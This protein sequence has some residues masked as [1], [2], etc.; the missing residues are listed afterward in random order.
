MGTRASKVRGHG[1]KGFASR[2]LLH[3]RAALLGAVPGGFHRDTAF[4]RRS[5]L[6]G[7]LGNARNRLMGEQALPVLVKSTRLKSIELEPPGT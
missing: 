3:T 5:I 1:R 7:Q 2:R 4:P 6:G